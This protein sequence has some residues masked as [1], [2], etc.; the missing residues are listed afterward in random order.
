MRIGIDA[1]TLYLPVLKGIGVYL[2]NLLNQL[3]VRDQKNEYILYYDSRQKIV[4]RA[5]KAPNFIT[6]GIEI[7]KS[8]RFYF[9]EQFCLPREL[10]RDR[11]DLLHSP[12]NTTCLGFRGPKVVTV[13]DT[14]IQQGKDKTKADTIYYNFIQ[15]FVLKFADRIITVSN[16]SRRNIMRDLGIRKKKIRV[17]PQGLDAAFQIIDDYS[18]VNRI[19][20]KYGIPNPYLLNVGGESPFKNVSGLLEAYAIM[21]RKYGVTE[22]LVVTG[23]RAKEIL[24]GHLEHIVRLGL[25]GKVIVLGYVPHEDLVALYNGARLFVYPSLMEGFGF[26]PLEAMACGTPTVV[27][28]AASM[29]DVA[30]NAAVLFDPKSPEDIAAKT[31]R[32]LVDETLR[33][34][35]IQRGLERV[36]MYDWKNTAEATLE[37]YEETAKGR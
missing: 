12:A 17:I 1:R 24:C 28:N 33:H 26:P 22:T 30:G 32:V 5:P 13:H 36:K 7:A 35:L 25:N 4:D 15:P 18:S 9:W 11:I 2:L 3:A 21:V 37:V 10:A 19:V 20:L 29:P 8:D 31:C 14:I 16:Y 34:E 6:R 23:I 27:S